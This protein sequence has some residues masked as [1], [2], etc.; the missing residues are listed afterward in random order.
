M[1]SAIIKARV[2]YIRSKASNATSTKGYITKYMN[3]LDIQLQ[4]A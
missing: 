1:E 2:S 3:T 4:K